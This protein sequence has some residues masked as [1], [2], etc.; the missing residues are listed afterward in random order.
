[1]RN[2]I[3]DIKNKLKSSTY[4]DN[5][6]LTNEMFKSS[7]TRRNTDK[8]FTEI[9]QIGETLYEKLLEKVLLLI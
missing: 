9:K 7:S 5:D 3:E 4:T 8:K 1:M 2:N 6:S